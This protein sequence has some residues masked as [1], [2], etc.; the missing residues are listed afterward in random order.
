MRGTPVLVTGIM[1][2]F[3]AWS[4]R[5]FPRAVVFPVARLL[6]GDHT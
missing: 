2:K 3:V 4:G 5:V 1:N 6:L